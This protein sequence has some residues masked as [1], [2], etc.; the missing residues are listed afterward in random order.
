MTEGYAI[1][2]V[3]GGGL[4][5]ET[6]SPTRRSAIVNWLFARKGVPVSS[7][8]DDAAIEQAWHR[9]RRDR[10]YCVKVSVICSQEPGADVTV[11]QDA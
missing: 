1:N 10:D 6:V 3:G 2:E 9:L 11:A 7:Q 8:W 4:R 5:I